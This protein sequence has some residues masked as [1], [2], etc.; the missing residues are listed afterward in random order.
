MIQSFE[1][2]NPVKLSLGRVRT[3][4]FINQSN[5]HVFKETFMIWLL[6]V[7]L[8]ELL[9][10]ISHVTGLSFFS[11][12]FIVVP[13]TFKMAGSF[14]CILFTTRLAFKR[15][16][17]TF[18][19]TIKTMIDLMCFFCGKAGECISNFYDLI[20]LA[21]RTPTS[22]TPYTSFNRI[23]FRSNNVILYFPST[24]IWSYRRR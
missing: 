14:T 3:L 4:C 17:Q 23:Q 2:F 7:T 8:Q 24:S 15:I 18:I 9:L 21:P 10:N 22:S 12:R 20:N 1:S 19:V 11:F 16:D 6:K 5:F 13:P